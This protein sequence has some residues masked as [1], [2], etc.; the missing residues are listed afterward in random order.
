MP[1]KKQKQKEGMD[2]ATGVSAGPSPTKAARATAAR[3][4]ARAKL[5]ASREKAAK[6]HAEE[7]K[8]KEEAEAAKKLKKQEEEAKKREKDDDRRKVEAWAKARAEAKKQS[9]TQSEAKRKADDP[10]ATAPVTDTGAVDPIELSEDEEEDELPAGQD[11]LDR[12]DR[13]LTTPIAGS[14]TKAATSSKT[15]GP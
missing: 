3:S 6:L 1:P 9:E 14:G 5:Q 15:A 10:P 11:L 2:V 8:R 13:G 7:V 12:F 4:D